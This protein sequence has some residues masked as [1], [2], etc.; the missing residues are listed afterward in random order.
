M[1][2]VSSTYLK[3]REEIDALL[4]SHAVWLK[5]QHEAGYF[6]SSGSNVERTGDSIL[7]QGITR[8]S[9]ESLLDQSPLVRAKAAHYAIM[10][11]SSVAESSPNPEPA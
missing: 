4:A 10:E 3:P 9:L 1:F 11:I 7:V 5:K 6:I 8:E 2:V